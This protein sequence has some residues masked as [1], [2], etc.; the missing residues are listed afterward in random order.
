MTETALSFSV[1]DVPHTRGT[2]C[3][4]FSI[5][6]KNFPKNIT[7]PTI[8]HLFSRNSTFFKSVRFSFFSAFVGFFS[9]FFP[10]FSPLHVLRAEPTSSFPNAV[11]EYN[12]R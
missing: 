11:F 10:F 4:L 12:I 5:F 6:R 7:K 8:S 9:H 2:I 3:Q 1:I